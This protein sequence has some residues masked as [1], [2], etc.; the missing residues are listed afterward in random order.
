MNRRTFALSLCA[1]LAA[2]AAAQAQTHEIAPDPRAAQAFRLKEPQPVGPFQLIGQDKTSFGPERFRGRWTFVFF[3][4]TFCPDIC[5]EVLSELAT[6]RDGIAAADKTKPAPS[7]LFISVDPDRDTPERLGQFVQNFG[8][9]IEGATAP[10]AGIRTV[11]KIFG[12]RHTIPPHQDPKNYV[13]DHTAEIYL[14]DPEARRVATFWPPADVDKWVAAFLALRNAD[15][16]SQ[17]AGL[18]RH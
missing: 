14:V 17:Q 11:E 18:A 2:G 12:A 16:P 4:Y 7:I 9:G 3:G 1:F 6:V 8:P 15:A 13:V 10:A 5:P